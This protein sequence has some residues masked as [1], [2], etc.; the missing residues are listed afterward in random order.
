MGKK[1]WD[2]D[3]CTN[4]TFAIVIRY[5]GGMDAWV[6]T[7]VQHDEEGKALNMDRLEV[8]GERTRA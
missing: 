2:R 1:F 7:G 8:V 4:T 5:R 3:G 6:G